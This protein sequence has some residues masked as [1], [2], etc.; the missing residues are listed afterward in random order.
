LLRQ[1]AADAA[2]AQQFPAGALYVVA[3][4]IGNLADL[5]LR[6]IHVLALADAIACED[7]RH[8]RVL[9]ER[10]GISAP[11]LSLH[12]HNERA[13]A[14]EL[15]AR[16][17][18]GAVVA[19]VSDAGM[20]LVPRI[21]HRKVEPVRPRGGFF[22]RNVPAISD[23]LVAKT[24]VHAGLIM[25]LVAAVLVWLYL[26]RTVWGFETRAVGHNAQAA[27]YAGMPVGRILLRAGLI[28]GALAGLAGAGEVAGLKGYLTSDLSPGFG[29]T[30]IVVAMLAQLNPLGVV[31]AAIFVAAVFVGADSMS[32]T[33]GVPSYIADLVV[34]L[35]LLT[36]LLAGMVT[37]Y[38]LRR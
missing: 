34:A 11:L 21:E 20:P 3:T 35:S 22:F 26:E 17:R 32:R 16:M 23:R 33:A 18:D 8:T 15:V 37:R 25:A 4:P 7:T 13:R 6:A 2:G 10:H 28:S 38:R 30:G 24:R 1:A 29:Y 5:T 27:A 9:L 36:M 12:E 14:G 31:L 19:L